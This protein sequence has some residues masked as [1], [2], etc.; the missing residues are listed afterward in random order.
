MF[1]AYT[2][3]ALKS[4]KTEWLLCQSLVAWWIRSSPEAIE[5]TESLAGYPEF[6]KPAI[7]VLGHS[8]ILAINR[9]NPCDVHR[10]KYKEH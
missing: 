2:H 7:S 4:R 9:C 5:D 8:L 6:V 10:R 1:H 3:E